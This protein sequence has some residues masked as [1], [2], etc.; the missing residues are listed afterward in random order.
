MPA[1]AAPPAAASANVHNQTDITFATEMVPHHAQ[2]VAMSKLAAEHAGSPQ[3]KNLAAR[4]EAAQQPEIDQLSGLLRSW[5]APVPATQAAGAGA[6]T[7]MDHDGAGHVD[8]PGMMSAQQMQQ[9][10]QTTGAAFDKMFLQMMI[11]HH[12]GAVSMAETERN[13]GQSSDAR[14]L[15]QRI[16]T[17]QQREIAEMHT[18]LAPW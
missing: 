11:D 14:G 12:E 6:I 15:A 7:G 18:M 8:M 16:M 2:A 17:A 4:I 10:A 3:V 13:S 5:K 1:N 9:L